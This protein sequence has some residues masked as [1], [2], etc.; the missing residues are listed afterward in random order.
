MSVDR[1]LLALL[2]AKPGTGDELAAFLAQ[3]RALGHIAPNLLAGEPDIRP[4]DII[5]VK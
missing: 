2:G 5:A 1:G 4:T 3:G